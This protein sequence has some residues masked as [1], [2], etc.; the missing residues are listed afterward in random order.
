VLSRRLSREALEFVPFPGSLSKPSPARQFG[1]GE[2]GTEKLF[3]P[4]VPPPR[5]FFFFS[6]I[7][8]MVH[9]AFL[10]V[11]HGSAVRSRLFSA[12]ARIPGPRAVAM[13]LSWGFSSNGTVLS[14]GQIRSISVLPPPEFSSFPVPRVLTVAAPDR[15]SFRRSPKKTWRCI[16]PLIFLLF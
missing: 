4:W 11:S 15:S 1:G 3:S 12:G 7:Q 13:A 16:R 9:R 10:N 14:V 8:F 6:P 2:S 5:F